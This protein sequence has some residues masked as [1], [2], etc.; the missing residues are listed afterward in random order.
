MKVNYFVL[1][2]S[3]SAPTTTLA[4]AEQAPLNRGARTGGRRL[5]AHAEAVTVIMSSQTQSKTRRISCHR[6]GL[7]LSSVH[8]SACW[9][10]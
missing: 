8:R 6:G 2:G 5:S 10:L 4:A 1:C 9:L 7:R 3:V